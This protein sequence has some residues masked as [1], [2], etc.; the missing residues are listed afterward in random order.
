MHSNSGFIRQGLRGRT[1]LSEQ[2]LAQDKLFFTKP[3]NAA[4]LLKLLDLQRRISSSI[5]GV[6][7][8][9]AR[10]VKAHFAAPTYS[11]GIPHQHHKAHG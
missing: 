5:F 10:G 6:V 7:G 8:E 2:D 3:T 11:A 9:C 1:E 4:G